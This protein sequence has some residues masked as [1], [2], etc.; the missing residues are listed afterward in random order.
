MNIYHLWRTAAVDEGE[1][2]AAVVLAETVNQAREVMAQAEESSVW[3]SDLVGVEL[4]GTAKRGS[5]AG[6][7]LTDC[8]EG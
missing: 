4:L 2:V 7:V 3:I 8:F 6:V 5:V 1:I